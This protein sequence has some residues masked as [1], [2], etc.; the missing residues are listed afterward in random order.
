[1]RFV[2]H[3]TRQFEI[4]CGDQRVQ[5]FAERGTGLHAT[6][7]QADINFQINAQEE[8]L[9][10]RQLSHFHDTLWGID[11]KLNLA[12]RRRP[13]ARWQCVE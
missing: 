8:F 9:P 1:M 4:G 7:V 3:K 5:H 10:T 12:R 6:A 11:Q 2:S 13:L